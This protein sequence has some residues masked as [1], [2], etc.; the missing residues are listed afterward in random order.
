MADYPLR[1]ATYH[2]LGGPL[3]H[4]LTNTPRDHPEVIAE[5]TFQTKSMR[6]LLLYGI[7]TCFQVLSPASGQISHVLLTSSPLASLLKSVQARHST[8]ARSTCMY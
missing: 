3:P 5:A 4:Q 8:E 2:R 1:S 6:T 7:S